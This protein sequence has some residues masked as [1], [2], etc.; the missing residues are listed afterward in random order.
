MHSYHI[1]H[2]PT[3]SS[4]SFYPILVPPTID[5]REVVEVTEKNDTSCLQS[6]SVKQLNTTCLAQL[7]YRR[8]DPD[9]FLLNLQHRSVWQDNLHR[10]S[11]SPRWLHVQL[12]SRE[13]P[14]WMTSSFIYAVQVIFV[15]N[16]IHW[17]GPVDCVGAAVV[18]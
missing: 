11:H 14:R 8:S 9:M 18:S 3:S 12:Y 16:A 7:R 1:I 10:S 13:R 4:L 2:S 5:A 15:T 6:L 17:T